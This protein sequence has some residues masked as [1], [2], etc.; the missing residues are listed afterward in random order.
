M[1]DELNINNDDLEELEA[2]SD[3]ILFH[4]DRTYIIN[5]QIRG[6]E[7]VE[8]IDTYN[9]AIQNDPEAIKIMLSFIHMFAERLHEMMC[10]PD[11]MVAEY[12]ES[13]FDD[14]D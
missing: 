7:A 8:W 10:V 9:R 4:E 13:A 12:N 14:E 6:I 2:V 3:D 11:D 1:S 5:H